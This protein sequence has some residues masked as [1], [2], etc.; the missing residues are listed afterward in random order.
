VKLPAARPAWVR[1]AQPPPPSRRWWW[2]GGGAAA[3]AVG[4]GLA[5]L[6]W[7]RRTPP[8]TPA[9][10][11]AHDLAHAEA[12]GDGKELGAR[13]SLALR[14]YAGVVYGFDGVGSTSRETAAWL[15][16]AA[17]VPAD[18]GRALVRLL[19]RL[20]ELRWSPGE[21][22]ASQV[23]PLL[24]EARAWS[25]AVEARRTAETAAADRR[26]GKAAP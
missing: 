20:D 23:R 18:E 10:V 15:R 3:L 25:D 16:T 13:L 1:P 9:E 6:L 24:S 12:A 11:L 2:I 21:L 26:P 17:G 5:W 8:P 4:C 14:R 22:D 7:R 19:D